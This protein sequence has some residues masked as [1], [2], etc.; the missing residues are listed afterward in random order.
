[1]FY[2]LVYQLEQKK[3]Q[4]I[5]KKLLLKPKIIDKINYIYLNLNS[6]IDFL[7]QKERLLPSLIYK[8]L[9]DAPNELLFIAIMESRS[10]IV[11]ERIVDFIKNYK[12]ERLCIS[13]KDLKKMGIKPGP[14]YSNI[15]SVLLSAKLDGEV[16]NKEEEIKF[17]LNLIEGKGK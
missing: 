10:S 9:K 3:I 16:N 2:F 17:V 5:C 4:K 1:Y 8:K 15:L 7:S 13:G 6:V 14:V 12:K 11:K